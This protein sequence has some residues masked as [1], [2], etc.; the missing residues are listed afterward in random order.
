MG[1]LGWAVGKGSTPFDDW[2]FWIGEH[3]PTH[4]LLFFS[5]PMLVMVVMMGAAA[6]AFDRGRERLALI[7]ILAPIVAWFLV[8]MFKRWSD[9]RK[10]GYYAFPSGHITLTVVVWG[11][12]VLVA[13][14]ALWSVYTSVGV[15]ALAV[16]GQ[17]TTYH[18]LT[19]TIGG[20]L[21]GSA[22]VCVAASAAKW[23][24]TRVNPVRPASHQVANMRS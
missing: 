2:F 24:L 6:V 18:Y 19:D 7:V 17:G 23:K 21:L 12:V 5:Q 3:S 8:Q 14:G 15:I 20:L 9:R 22:I 1:I 10:Q 11:M 13:G 16:I 4:L